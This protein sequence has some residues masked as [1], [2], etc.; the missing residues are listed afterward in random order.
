MYQV[1][2]IL[3]KP[4]LVNEIIEVAEECGCIGATIIK[5]RKVDRK[6][7]KTILNVE[8]DHQISVIMMIVRSEVAPKLIAQIEEKCQIPND[9]HGLI[10][11]LPSS[12]VRGLSQRD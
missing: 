4:E 6:P 1:I 7:E 5:A 12:S 2:Q 9:E 8:I 11:S 10:I 3:A